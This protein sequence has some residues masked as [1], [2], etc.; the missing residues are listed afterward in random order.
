MREFWTYEV[1]PVGSDASGL[2]DYLVETSEGNPAGKVVAVLEHDGERFI[3]FD[4]G[5]G[6]KRRAVRWSAVRDVD[7]DALTVYLTLDDSALDQALELDRNDKV[8]GGEAEAVRVT[9]LPSELARPASPER[10]PTDRP[11]YAGAIALFALGLIGLLA[12]ALAASGTAF[13]WEF[14]LFAIPGL[15]LAAAAALAYRAYRRPYEG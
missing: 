15:L 10:G 7:H 6:R 4:G 13:T 2:E 8:E 3:A 14:A 5:L 12:L 1:P 9:Q 11:T